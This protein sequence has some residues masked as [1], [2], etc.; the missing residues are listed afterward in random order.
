MSDLRDVIALAK[1]DPDGAGAQAPVVV[2]GGTF[3]GSGM[4]YIA[5]W[6]GGTWTQ[7]GGGANGPVLS[8]AV[9][10]NGDLVVGGSFTSIGGTSAA[11]IARWDGSSWTAL[12]TGLGGSS[13][14][15]V[16]NRFGGPAIRAILPLGNGDL[17]VGGSFSTAGGTSIDNV[18][19]WNGSSWSGFGSGINGPVE[20]IVLSGSNIIAGGTFS[21]A[22]GNTANNLAIWNGSSWSELGGGTN[23]AVY[24]LA[25][26]GSDLYVG[27]YFTSANGSTL[28]SPDIARW[29]G[30]SWHSMGSGSTD[31][32][33]L[34]L[35]IAPNGDV[36]AGGDFST[37]AGV[38]ASGVAKWNGSAW[39]ALD[40]G[41][42]GSEDLCYALLFT[43]NGDLIAG[44]NIASAGATPA[45][46]VARW[47]GERTHPLAS[48][49]WHVM[50]N[51]AAGDL[52]NSP[53]NAMTV[54]SDGTLVIGGTFT[55]AGGVNANY[56]VRWDGA[57]WIPIGT[58]MNGTV[59]ALTTMPNG[60]NQDLIAG[61]DFTQADGN[62]VNYVA[63]WDGAAWVALNTNVNP[64]FVGMNNSVYAL[65]YTMT[66]GLIAGGYFTH[67]GTHGVSYIAQFDGS[68]N[69]QNPGGFTGTDGPVYA[70]VE[71]PNDGTLVA[72][73]DFSQA[74]GISI[75]YGIATLDTANLGC[76][77]AMSN[78]V[79]GGGVRALAARANGH[80]IV[81]GNFT[82]ADAYPG[83]SNTS[84][85]TE[86]DGSSWNAVGTGMNG[87]VNALLLLASGPT[88][89]IVAAGDFTSA[90]GTSAD[91]IAKWNGSSWSAFTSGLNS[92]AS[93]LAKMPSGEIEVGGSFSSAGGQTVQY[94]ARWSENGQPWI[95]VQPMHG[96][97]PDGTGDISLNVV[98][99]TGYEFGGA[100]TYQWYNGSTA[101]VDGLHGASALGGTVFGATTDTLL[102]T[103]FNYHDRGSYTVR[104]DNSCNHVTSTPG[105]L[106]MGCN[107]D[108]NADC[109][110]SVQ[111]IF[112]FLNAWFA[113]DPAADFNGTAGITVQDIFDFLNGWFAGCF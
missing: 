84:N 52:L 85:I 97:C 54:L 40:T 108:F 94:F 103:G 62:T 25:L 80:I 34:A 89:N 11:G 1:W 13:G 5:Y 39:Q 57:N 23:H 86:W 72:G 63:R 24:A 30:S 75:G 49:A 35:A 92:T 61:G 71:N 17:V 10:A 14:N 33:V 48:S 95:A 7:L 2:A 3:N 16:D 60:S 8:L 77:C 50:A 73:G 64:S 51:S 22:D 74:D 41:L 91:R 47:D 18:A 90:G 78:G 82:Y 68:N 88:G 105:I 31:D 87:A 32:E 104:I 43:G 113:G 106:G 83:V 45:K 56:V 21:L 102:I 37:I 46:G 53:A 58:G 36:L 55:Q 70:L 100:L 112:D 67:A 9:A 27:G 111:D 99:A 4:D 96:A 81:G 59:R 42:G 69:W 12:G 76:W 38:S 98:A 107:A 110:L 26:S 28:A 20:A 44:G 29:D 65:T 101:V 6:D 19:K 93:C 66:D 79:G 15:V 109:F